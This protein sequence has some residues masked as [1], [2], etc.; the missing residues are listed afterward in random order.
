MSREKILVCGFQCNW[1]S[2]HQGQTH[3][4]DIIM[5]RALSPLGTEVWLEVICK[6][7]LT[8][9]NSELEHAKLGTVLSNT[10]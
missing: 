8:E 6:L 5:S 1:N 9:L 3:F 10:G 7:S 4:L 2:R